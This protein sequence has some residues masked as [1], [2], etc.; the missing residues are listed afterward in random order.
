MAPG[1]GL[2]FVGID[3]QMVNLVG[4]RHPRGGRPALQQALQPGLMQRCRLIAQQQTLI[5][6]CPVQGLGGVERPLDQ[7]QLESGCCLEPLGGDGVAVAEH[8]EPSDPPVLLQAPD[9]QQGPQG[10]ARPWAGMDQHVLS[11]RPPLAQAG[12]QQLDQL[13]LPLARLQRQRPAQVKGDGD[14]RRII[15]CSG[16]WAQ[17]AAFLTSGQHG[18]PHGPPR[19]R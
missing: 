7:V 18:S 8:H 17:P 6:C 12:A 2:G 10:L 16:L 15:E 4:D 14:H 19:S 3:P 5:G 9:R 13:A 1:G 11:L